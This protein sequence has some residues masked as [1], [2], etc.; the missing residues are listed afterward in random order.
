M[1][2]QNIV[3]KYSE[4]IQNDRTMQ[5][6]VDHLKSEVEELEEELITPGIDGIVGEAIDIITCALDAIYKH[7]PNITN[8]ELNQITLNKCEKWKRKYSLKRYQ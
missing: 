8:E 5:D 3:R 1:T 2:I 4:E 6:I 7:N